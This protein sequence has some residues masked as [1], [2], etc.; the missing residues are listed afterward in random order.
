[1]K[2]SDTYIETKTI[3]NKII[4]DNNDDNKYIMKEYEVR[5]IIK[6]LIPR[7]KNLYYVWGRVATAILTDYNCRTKIKN[8]N[9]IIELCF[10]IEKKIKRGDFDIVILDI[11]NI[12][13]PLLD[14]LTI[15]EINIIKETNRIEAGP[16][17]EYNQRFSTPQIFIDLFINYNMHT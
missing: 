1:M 17:Y 16:L 12:L 15:E 2:F 10:E 5:T 8:I 7:N 13:L 14:K 4:L 3:K 6:E 11:K 9:K